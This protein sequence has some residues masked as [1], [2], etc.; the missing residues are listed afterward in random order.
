MLMEQRYT[1]DGFEFYYE[2]D[3]KKAKEELAKINALSSRIDADNLGALKAVYTKAVEQKIFETQVGLH[4]LADIRSYLLSKG[5]LEDNECPIPVLFTRT[6]VQNQTKRLSEEYDTFKQKVKKD[7]DEKIQKEKQENRRLVHKCR[8]RNLACALL[9]V[10]VVIM[11][12]IS[13]TGNNPTVLNYKRAITNQY[14]E[15]EQQLTERE[16]AVREKEAELSSQN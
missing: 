9:V 3:E 5:A 16:N 11:F 8:Q 4:Y 2:E 14:A 13:M 6:S 12:V 15:W 10:M 1:I 7:A